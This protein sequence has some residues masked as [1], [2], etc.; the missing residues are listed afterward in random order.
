[1]ASAASG[2]TGQHSHVPSVASSEAGSS[3]TWLPWGGICTPKRPPVKEAP[4]GW[5]TRQRLL[6]IKRFLGFGQHARVHTEETVVGADG[7]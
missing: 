4:A 1:M 5:A 2:A 6:G 7:L 3:K